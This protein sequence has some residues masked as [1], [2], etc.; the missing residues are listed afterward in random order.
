MSHKLRPDL[1]MAASILGL[2][3]YE[4]YKLAAEQAT[5]NLLCET[6]F[7]PVSNHEYFVVRSHRYPN[8]PPGIFQSKDDRCNCIDRIKECDQ[9]AH[10]I[11][12]RVGLILL[13]SLK[14]TSQES[15]SRDHSLVGR[16]RR[17]I[18]CET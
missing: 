2:P 6:H 15:A 11:L 7:D 8:A 14:D 13:V 12:L 1:V 18:I 16:N 4:R 5:C 10:E 3:S 17:H 9:C